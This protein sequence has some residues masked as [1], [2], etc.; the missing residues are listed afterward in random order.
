MI[1]IYVLIGASF[2]SWYCCIATRKEQPKQTYS[3]RSRCDNC[4]TLIPWYD[5]VPIVSFF[6]LNGK[7][8]FCKAVIDYRLAFIE[9]VG[10]MNFALILYSY[11]YTPTLILIYLILFCLSIFDYFSLSVPNL[12]LYSLFALSLFLSPL[13]VASLLLGI[14]ISGL[15][16]ALNFRQRIIGNADIILIV[17]YFNLFGIT[18]CLIIVFCSCIAA[19]LC[20]LI[21]N[22]D[23]NKKIPF[24]PFLTAGY[25]IFILLSPLFRQFI[26]N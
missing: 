13:N 21:F 24:I 6:I 16:L 3:S 7:C 9:I 26:T 20:I 12:I 14:T 11:S 4:H 10:G 19:L 1:I 18:A 23:S 17:S 22:W 25:L 15:L 5:L 8:R 2:A